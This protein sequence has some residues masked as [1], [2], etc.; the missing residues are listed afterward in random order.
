MGKDTLPNP[1][2]FAFTYKKNARYSKAHASQ[3]DLFA[4][5]TDG[6]QN[7]YKDTHMKTPLTRYLLPALVILLAL[8]APSA[9]AAQT[10]SPQPEA[11]PAPAA[12]TASSI[13][14]PA[15]STLQAALDGVRLERWKTSNAVR[16]ETDANIASVRRD[17]DSTLPPLLATA[18]AAPDS[19]A[20]VLP[21]YR[22]IEALYDVLLRISAVAMLSAPP[23]QSDALQQAMSSMESSRRTLGDQ[24][25]SS[26]VNQDRNIHTLQASLRAAPPAAPTPAPCPPPP[27]PAKKRKPHHKPA[28]P[29][30]AT[31]QTTPPPTQ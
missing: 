25:Q 29:P 7:G 23:A 27:A 16:E 18:D 9:L 11:Q 19:V 20:Q 6:G 12:S 28:T 22:N 13:F 5:Q 10:P 17:L 2:G 1:A 15:I 21:A 31:P 14:N 30:A 26:A 8:S 24:L 3:D 4:R